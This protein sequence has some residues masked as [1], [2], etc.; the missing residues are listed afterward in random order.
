M[1]E[2]MEKR[3]SSFQFNGVGITSKKYRVPPTYKRKNPMTNTQWRRFQRNK[4]DAR[5]ATL[6]VAPSKGKRI[7]NEVHCRPAKERLLM[8]IVSVPPAKDE[9]LGDDNMDDELSDDFEDSS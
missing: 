7:Q 1:W 6:K 9:N 4:K 5:E 3:S 2:M 8:P